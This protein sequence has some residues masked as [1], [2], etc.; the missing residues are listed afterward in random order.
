MAIYPPADGD[1]RRLVDVAVQVEE[2]GFDSAWVGD[3][4]LAKP[5]AEPLSILAATAVATSRIELG[6]AVLLAAMR[7]AEQLAQQAATVDALAGGRLVLG[8]GYGPSGP[9]AEAD[10]AFAASDFID[11]VR[12]TVNVVER[13]RQLWRGEGLPTGT[14]RLQP[15]AVSRGGPRVWMGGAGP[16][17]RHRAGALYDGWFPLATDAVTYGSALRDVRAAAT[18]AGRTDR[19][20]TAAV[21][22]TINIGTPEASQRE[23]AEYIELYYGQP[24]ETMSA[25]MGVRAGA[26]ED[27]AVWLQGFLDAGCQHMCLRLASPDFDTQL[28]RLSMLLPTLRG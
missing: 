2:L 26:D 18:E 1:P 14:E 3:S 28:D 24:L 23:L 8:V 11:R 27:V 20:V 12:T 5:R 19:D 13:A 22:L 16:L 4:L 10:F 21:Y 9:A 25:H 15:L 7:R 6:T 17:S